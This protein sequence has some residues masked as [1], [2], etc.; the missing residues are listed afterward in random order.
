MIVRFIASAAKCVSLLSGMVSGSCVLLL[1]LLITVD[2]LGRATIGKTTLVA[3][4]ISRYLLLAIVYLGLATTQ[5]AGKHI[6]VD[7]FYSRLLPER[8]VKILKKAT[9]IVA[10]LFVIWLTWATWG[11]VQWSYSQ[12]AQS[13][14]I[15]RIP[16]WVP[17]LLIPLGL[18]LFVIQLL[19]DIVCGFI[20]EAK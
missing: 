3:D 14:S 12:R 19:A 9:L 10:L 11:P 20:K 13:L 2:I 18:A 17:N 16:L 4:E 15:V 8:Y 5:K 1:V 6:E 7:M